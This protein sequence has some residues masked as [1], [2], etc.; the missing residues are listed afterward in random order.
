MEKININLNKIIKTKNFHFCIP[1][2][3]SVSHFAD[4]VVI[5]PLN[6]T[7]EKTEAW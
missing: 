3:G 7:G 1:P 6:G 2:V 5:E 4:T